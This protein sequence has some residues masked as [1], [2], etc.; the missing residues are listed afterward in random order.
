MQAV[1]IQKEQTLFELDQSWNKLG[2]LDEEN[3]DYHAS[4]GLSFSGVKQLA[5]TPAHYI[6]SRMRDDDETASQRLGTLVHMAILEPI[7]FKASV[8]A[9]EG[10]RGRT[11]VKAAIAEAEAQGKYVCKPEEY[12]VT[13][14]MAE[15]ILLNPSAKGL[16]TGGQAEKSIRWRDPKTGVLLKCRP[17]YLRPDGIIIDLKTFDDL[18]EANIQKQIVKMK[19]HWQSAFYL[20]GVN[21]VLNLKSKMFVHIFID[22][23][24]FVSRVVVLDDASI[25]NAEMSIQ[26]LIETYAECLKK[27]TWTGYPGDILTT[28][29]P[30]WGW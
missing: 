7:R 21:Q 13:W 22:T 5:K 3:E 9:I 10:H 27:N 2:V 20:A 11:D 25:E 8:V 17:D 12:E 18:S 23:K 19:Y 28:S 26:P 15:A 16:L 4:V 30:S 14:K 1:Q 24:A 29:L 6:A